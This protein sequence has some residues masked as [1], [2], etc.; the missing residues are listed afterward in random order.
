M[1]EESKHIGTLHVEKSQANISEVESIS[2]EDVERSGAG[3][4]FSAYYNVTCAIAGTGVLGLPSALAQGG[5]MG[6]GILVLAWLLAMYCGKLL[7]EC[8]YAPNK[9]NT[10]LSSYKL[11]GATAFGPIGGWLVYFFQVW[12]MIGAPIL[13]I[14]LTGENLN[15]V[16]KGTSAEL[17]S[18]LW[19]IIA[20]CIV[21]VPFVFVKT[22]RDVA[23]T[24]LFGVLT[25]LV[26]AF[27]FVGVAASDQAAGF[28]NNVDAQGM[29]LLP[30]D[31]QHVGVIWSQFPIALSTIAF[32]F[33][34]NVVYP[35]VEAAM[36][37]P[38]HWNRAM[39]ASLC[40]C[41]ALYL[42]VAVAGYQIFG[43]KVQSPAYNSISDGVP[44]IAAVVLMT[45]SIIVSVPI[46]TVSFAI[47][48]ETMM[49]FYR[50]GPKKEFC[51][52]V[53]FRTA[54]MA[55]I[56]TIACTV[57]SFG[58]FM[59][60]LGAV[61]NCLLVFFGPVMCHLKLFGW[62]QRPWYELAVCALCVLLSIVG[63][64]FGSYQS[65]LGLIDTF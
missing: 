14:L 19:V 31:I 46:Y 51:A 13:Y 49:H 18:D 61:S 2:V 56:A 5:W 43:D 25:I 38:Q 47:D 15:L 55:F 20:S 44:K 23:W 53:A 27:I 1:S 60:L 36:A 54:I 24:S 65:I 16:F 48:A 30:S 33:G 11:I 39:A 59:S 10:R 64:I 62:R 9:N 57:T 41:F 21:G 34:G 29:P 32:S 28:I 52:R 50:L 6:I 3:S 37:K 63:L 17:T 58:M 22:M 4:S 8:L 7:V 35:N 45:L 12:L 40:T 26:V 42:M